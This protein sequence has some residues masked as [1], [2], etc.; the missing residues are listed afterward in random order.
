MKKVSIWIIEMRDVVIDY[1]ITLHKSNTLKMSIT[2]SDI[3]KDNYQKKT[4]LQI[5]HSYS[6]NVI[7]L[8]F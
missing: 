6:I 5:A 4:H 7:Y 3:D 8:S 2:H 1:P